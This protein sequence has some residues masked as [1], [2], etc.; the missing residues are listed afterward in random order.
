M[1]KPKLPKAATMM[2]ARGSDAESKDV[3]ATIAPL[4]TFVAGLATGAAIV[5]LHRRMQ[6]Y[7]SRSISA[8]P[9]ACSG[10]SSQTELLLCS[11]CGQLLPHT[12]FAAKQARRPEASRKCRWCVEGFDP[13]TKCNASQPPAAPAQAAPAPECAVDRPEDPHRLARKAETVLRGRTER[14]CLILENCLNDLNHIA[15]LRT[16]EALGVLH[17]WCVSKPLSTSDSMHARTFADV[18]CSPAMSC[19]GSS[20]ASKKSASRRAKRSS[21]R[22]PREAASRAWRERR[23]VCSSSAAA[24][25]RCRRVGPASPSMR[26]LSA[27]TRPPDGHACLSARP[28]HP[29]V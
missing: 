26:R 27:A 3:R 23:A 21:K 29:S 13:S 10:A 11:M 12:A 25:H 16:C 5:H 6:E 18:A 9:L 24:A 17:V 1:T 7:C 4:V 19:A 22:A 14:I 8:A 15:I 2:A 28:A 20:A